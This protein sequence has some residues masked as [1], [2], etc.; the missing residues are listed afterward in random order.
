MSDPWNLFGT[1]ATGV[2]TTQ[3]RDGRPQLS[4]VGYAW[5]PATRVALISVTDTRAKTRNLRRD[6]RAGLY[7]TTSDLGAYAVGEG[8][9]ELTAVS[10]APDDDVV[11]QLV[12]YYRAL[13]GEHPDWDEYRRAMVSERRLLVRLPLTHAYG[14]VPDHS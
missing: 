12:E 10:A 1:T 14:W 9:A 7:V 3:K 6:P 13:A 5:D 11:N 8:D 2:L 4:N